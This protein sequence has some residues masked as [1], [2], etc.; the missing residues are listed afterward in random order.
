MTK[1][2]AHLS[3]S[4]RVCVKLVFFRDFDPNFEHYLVSFFKFM[5]M[6]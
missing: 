4:V 3:C 6:C 1:S 5:W 2:A